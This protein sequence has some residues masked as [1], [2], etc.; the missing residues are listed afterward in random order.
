MSVVMYK[1]FVKTPGQKR[2][3]LLFSADSSLN[4]KALEDARAYLLQAT[5]ATEAAKTLFLVECIGRNKKLVI[6]AQGLK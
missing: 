3:E 4:S 2:K 5:V 1:V 6:K